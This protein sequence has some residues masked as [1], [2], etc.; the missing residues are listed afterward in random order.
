VTC[1]TICRSEGFSLKTDFP[2]SI[3]MKEDFKKRTAAPQWSR[4]PF[5]KSVE[6]VKSVISFMHY[7]QSSGALCAG[8]C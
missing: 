6:F 5:K 8:L 3:K 4:Y 1:S 7:L 2:V